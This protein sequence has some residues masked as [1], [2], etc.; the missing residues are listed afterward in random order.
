MQNTWGLY[1][2]FNPITDPTHKWMTPQCTSCLSNLIPWID[3]IS[4]G[5]IGYCDSCKDFYVVK[6]TWKSIP[7]HDPKLEL[8]ELV[9]HHYFKID[10]DKIGFG[11]VNK[12]W[13]CMWNEIV[14]AHS[15]EFDK[16]MAY[17]Q[18]FRGATKEHILVQHLLW[19]IIFNSEI[20]ERNLVTEYIY[21]LFKYPHPFSMKGINIWLGHEVDVA[22]HL[23]ESYQIEIYNGIYQIWQ[24]QKDIYTVGEFKKRIGFYVPLTDPAAG[25]FESKFIEFCGQIRRR[26]IA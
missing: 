11:E 12:M 21:F 15:T 5:T 9:K 6:S 16:I 2:G 25:S 8:E 23:D 20:D 4:Q 1:R 7:G 18:E 26:I 10:F 24:G 14:H 3:W 13:L 19:S 17:K 22:A